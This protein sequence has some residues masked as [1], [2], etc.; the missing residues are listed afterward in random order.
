LA[1]LLNAIQK[2]KRHPGRVTLSPLMPFL[3]FL[4]LFLTLSEQPI[5]QGDAHALST[6]QAG[7]ELAK[8]DAGSYQQ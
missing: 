4:T 7:Q 8:P 3:S 5:A 1:L 6:K 2:K